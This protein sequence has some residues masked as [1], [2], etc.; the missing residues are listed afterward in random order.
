MHEPS[1]YALAEKPENPDGVVHIGFAGSADRGQDVD[2]ILAEAL[3]EV[4]RK[5]G[6]RI[7]IEI[8]GTD[9]EIARRLRCMTIPYTESYEA[10]QEKMKELNWDIGLA[11]M[12]ET[13][14]HA[15]KYYNKL[16]EYA[17]YGIVGIYSKCPALY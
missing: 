12:P 11:P 1:A 8:F 7:S 2:T 15:C 17:G 4:S 9:T 16:V 14:F 13:A 6:D 5:Y 10:Y 3:E